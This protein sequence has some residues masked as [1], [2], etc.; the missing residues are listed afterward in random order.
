MMKKSFI[1]LAT[2]LCIVLFIVA[3]K[4]IM[5]CSSGKLC[6]IKKML[7]IIST[8]DIENRQIMHRHLYCRLH[9]V[10]E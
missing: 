8:T 5:F 3:V 6:H 2:G 7:V 1:T 10:E 9:N 4:L